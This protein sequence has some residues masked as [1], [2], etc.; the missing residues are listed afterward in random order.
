MS[1]ATDRKRLVSGYTNAGREFLAYRLT[2]LFTNIKTQDEVA[3]HNNIMKEL[4]LM[5]TEANAGEFMLDI[6][7]RILMHSKKGLNDG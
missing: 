6:A 4:D 5:I 7:D 2:Y 3:L 1:K